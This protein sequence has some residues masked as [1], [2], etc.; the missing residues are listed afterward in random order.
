MKRIALALATL[1]LGCNSPDPPS[2]KATYVQADYAKDPEGKCEQRP[3]SFYAE[4][5]KSPAGIEEVMA[6]ACRRDVRANYHERA[7]AKALAPLRR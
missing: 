5:A 4:H 3:A 1:L 2:S 6:L 7:A